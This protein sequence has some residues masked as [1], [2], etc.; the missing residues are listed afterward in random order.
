LYDG[1]LSEVLYAPVERP[2]PIDQRGRLEVRAALAT[3]P[4]SVVIVQA[5]RSEKWKGHEQ[6]LDALAALRDVRGWTWWQVGG[7]QRPHER[8]FLARL[9]DKAIRAGVADRIRWL[10]E[11]SDIG[12]L[13]GAADLYCQPNLEP[14]PFGIAFVEALAA[15]L[16][17][18]TTHQGGAQEIVDATCGVLVPPRQPAALAAALGALV[19]DSGLRGQLAATTRDRAERLCDPAT[20]LRRLTATLTAMS[21]IPV[22]V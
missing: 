16:P 3:S 14:E 18:V 6:L 15:G 13:L 19:A 7:A 2:R 1:V 17:V 12:R 9:R 10:G 21:A 4:A 20:Q 11:R 8:T 5:C 22:P